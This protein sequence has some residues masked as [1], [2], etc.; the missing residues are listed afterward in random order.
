MLVALVYCQEV[1]VV[2]FL[3]VSALVAS[4]SLDTGQGRSAD[5]MDQ[6]RQS[7]RSHYL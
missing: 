3:I 5:V 2:G 4:F 6:P 7:H 1:L